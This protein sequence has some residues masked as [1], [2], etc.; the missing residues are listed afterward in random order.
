MDYIAGLHSLAT[1]HK[2][3]S[4]AT[5]TSCAHFILVPSFVWPLARAEKA[6]R[7]RD[8]R[9]AS[10]LQPG[11]ATIIPCSC[12]RTM[13]EWFNAWALRN[14]NRAAKLMVPS[15]RP[16]VPV[17]ALDGHVDFNLTYFLGYS[18]FGS[19]ERID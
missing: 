8:S 18:G 16:N 2:N 19:W 17:M 15:R 7:I 5:R 9:S 10:E 3:R 13:S 11:F 1:L 14:P 4:L 6:G 12:T